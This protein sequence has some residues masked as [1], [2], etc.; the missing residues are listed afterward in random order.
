V[1]L[2]SALMSSP[3]SLKASTHPR[4][5][6]PMHAQF[7][8]GGYAASKILQQFHLPSS[9]TD[10]F[11][12][13]LQYFLKQ[14][15]GNT[16]PLSLNASDAYATVDNGQLPA[17]V[18]HGRSLTPTASNLRT[19]LAPGDYVVPVTAYC[20]QYSVHRPGQGTAYKLAPVEG[21]QSE[22]ISTLLWRGTL[23]G[24]G[25]QE[26]Q[27]TNW[28]IQAGVTYDSMPKPY[29]TLIDQLIPEYRDGLHGN[30]LD[31]IQSRY[32]EVTSDPRMALQTYIKQKYDKTVP[33]M[34]LP[35]IAI[36]APALE[37]VMAKMGPPGQLMLDAR[38]QTDILL[39]AYTT[40]ERGEQV[41][42]QG[43]GDR[44]PPEPAGE[45]PWTVR[46]PGRAYMRFIVQGGNMQGNNLM[47]IRILPGTATEESGKPRLMPTA[48]QLSPFI[49]STK[50]LSSGPA[51]TVVPSTSIVPA[52]SVDGLL[53]LKSFG[54]DASADGLKAT[55][56]IGYSQGGQGAQALIPV[57][58]V[59]P[60]PCNNPEIVDTYDPSDT[61]I[62][63][64][65]H[66]YL[67]E[68]T[69]CLV[70]SA[71]CSADAV[72]AKMISDSTF[73]A[74]TTDKSPVYECKKTTVQIPVLGS[75]S[76]QTMVS[77]QQRQIINYTL[78]DHPL[79]NGEVIRTIISDPGVGRVYVRTEG[80]GD[81]WAPYLNE[82]NAPNV[83]GEVDQRLKNAEAV[84]QA[85]RK[86][87]S[88]VP[89]L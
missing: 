56:V 12:F 84:P 74:P 47:Q 23:A 69:I 46:I 32:K 7:G 25:P 70:E 16:L 20:T 44:L 39:T 66:H 85:K 87:H 29:K 78:S 60:A 10:L 35:K 52:T 19:A 80:F 8:V 14:E 45:G 5:A 50:E 42:F 9:P 57:P 53:G 51:A 41:L 1:Y 40:K 37:V 79:K 67:V 55:G 61:G 64:G 28:A 62:L 4:S 18:F 26:L 15:L 21:V 89:G 34:M 27:A 2:L 31:V 48:Y 72:F 43:Q 73:L 36:P 83:W 17:G 86:A 71:G 63:K 54:S 75:G 59:A 13:L 30:M 65:Y 49:A 11:E 77:P 88:K 82:V 6:S 22:A 24:K 68:T 58:V 76:I 81:G 3:A 38:K 33:M